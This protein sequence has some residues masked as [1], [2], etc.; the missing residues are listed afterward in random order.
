MAALG[1][2]KSQAKRKR[3]LLF[4]L[5]KRL[6]HFLIFWIITLRPGSSLEK[7]QT[8]LCKFCGSNMMDSYPFIGPK[9]K[10]NDSQKSI[11]QKRRLF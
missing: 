5:D 8:I 11:G 3:A 10:K 9:K 2:E 4:E 6:G 1:K 7:H